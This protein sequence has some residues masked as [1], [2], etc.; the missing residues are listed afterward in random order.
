MSYYLR[1]PNTTPQFIGRLESERA[2]LLNKV[3]QVKRTKLPSRPSAAKEIRDLEY[4]IRRNELD[5]AFNG[6]EWAK[7]EKYGIWESLTS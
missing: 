1:Q 2:W 7:Y 6:P 5:L 4:Q 3:E